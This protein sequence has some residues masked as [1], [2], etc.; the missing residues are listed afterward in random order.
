MASIAYIDF[1]LYDPCKKALQFSD[2]RLSVGGLII[3]DEALTDTW[4]GE[5]Q[6]LREFM[7]DHKGDYEMQSNT[8]SRQPTVILKKVR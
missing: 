6:A 1:D 3:L 4:K 7:D 5:G 8:I 2:R